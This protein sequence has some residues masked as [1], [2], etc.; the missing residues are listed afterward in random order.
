MAFPAETSLS[1]AMYIRH[2][3]VKGALRARVQHQL[4]NIGPSPNHPLRLA[5]HLSVHL[6]VYLHV[7]MSPVHFH[8]EED[9]CNPDHDHGHL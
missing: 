6:H 1:A 7:S 5:F 8:F 2:Y 9:R 4:K 3:P